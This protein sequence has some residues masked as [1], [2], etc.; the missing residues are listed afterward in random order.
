[1]TDKKYGEKTSRERK[2]DLL[3]SE[4]KELEKN[5]ADR[6]KL[7]LHRN[8]ISHWGLEK[9]RNEKNALYHDKNELAKKRRKLEKETG[10]LK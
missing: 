8:S 4:I 1:M 2:L 10:A 6:E 5:C 3:C 9:M 7:I